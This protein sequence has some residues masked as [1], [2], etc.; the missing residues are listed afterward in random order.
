[1]GVGKELEDSDFTPDFV[2][3]V[4]RLDLLLVEDFDGNLNPGLLVYREL[5]FT[6]LGRF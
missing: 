4:E 5:H 6:C 2:I 3:H 1:M